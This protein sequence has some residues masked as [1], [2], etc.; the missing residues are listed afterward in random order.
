MTV[1]ADNNT[2][3]TEPGGPEEE[4]FKPRG[5]IFLLACYVAVIILLWISVYLILLSRGV[6]V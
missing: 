4:H 3:E 5:T 2:P 6:T 1:D